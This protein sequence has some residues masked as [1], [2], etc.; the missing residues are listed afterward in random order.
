MRDHAKHMAASRSEQSAVMMSH[1]RSIIFHS[2][3][4]RC[5]PFS[6]SPPE[7]HMAVKIDRSDDS[8]ILSVLSTSGR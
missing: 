4:L 3:R 7:R 1:A 2:S 8:K 6:P 5:L